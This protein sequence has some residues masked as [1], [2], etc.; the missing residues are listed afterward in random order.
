MI[1]NIGSKNI[2]SRLNNSIRNNRASATGKSLISR[3]KNADTFTR[4][5]FSSPAE[6]AS[7]STNFFA[8]NRKQIKKLQEGVR[9]G[10]QLELSSVEK[11]DYESVA[12]NNFKWIDY[13]EKDINECIPK[14]LEEAG[15][16]SDLSFEFDYDLDSD[17]C[18]ITK[19]SDD[20]YRENVESVLNGIT[21]FPFI[22]CASR[23]MNGYTSSLYYSS[24]GRAL[25]RCFEQDISELYIDE[26]GK[27]CGTNENLQKA[28][29]AENCSEIS[30]DFYATREKKFPADNIEGI[31][32]RLI[33]DENITANISHMGYDSK[34]IYTNDGEFKLGKDFA[35]GLFSNKHYLMR[36]TM[37][38]YFTAYNYDWWLSNEKM[39]Y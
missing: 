1:M 13:F 35:P 31:I 12:K 6:T 28:L 23:V 21:G 25:D 2:L 38:L 33:S 9:N 8:E 3:S 26:N 10:V 34:Q 36:G 37:A 18:E 17:K 5:S 32:R 27:L 30:E 7:I 16:P 24:I 4:S 14:R 15:V 29:D 19:I 11:D 22:A 20:I 39:L